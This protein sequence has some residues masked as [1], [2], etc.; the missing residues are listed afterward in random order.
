MKP[1][2]QIS[3]LCLVL[4]LQLCRMSSIILFFSY[5]AYR[6]LLLPGPAGLFWVWM[7][8]HT[9]GLGFNR[10]H[11]SF[12][13]GHRPEWIIHYHQWLWHR[14]KAP[15]IM[16]GYLDTS[17]FSVSPHLTLPSFSFINYVY[18]F[19]PLNCDSL[20]V[21]TYLLFIFALIT[22]CSIPHDSPLCD[23]ALMSFISICSGW[24]VKPYLVYSMP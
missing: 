6:C 20:R 2:N 18:D 15:F 10:S 16:K 3:V 23:L 11:P 9:S 5:L 8:N 13:T 24:Y 12:S 17:C 4:P 1:L 7:F 19:P 21:G 14:F 22:Y